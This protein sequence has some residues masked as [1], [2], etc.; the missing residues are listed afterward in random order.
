MLLL[1]GT[2]VMVGAVQKAPCAN[3]AWVEHRVGGYAH[4]YSDVTDLYEWEQLA[5]G[6]LPYLDACRPSVHL[7]DEYPVV[8]MYVMR[9]AAWIGGDQPEDFASF[10]WTNVLLLLSCALA[11]AWCLERL[12]AK[13][14]LFAAAPTLLVYGTMNWDLVP[15]A[16]ATAATYLF[17]RGRHSGTGIGLGLGAAAKVYPAL[18]LLPFAADDAG[19]RDVRGITRMVGWFGL[20]W[21]VVNVPFAIAARHQWATTFRFNAL[22]PPEADSLWRAVTFNHWLMGTR[23]INILS[24][25]IPLVATLV[26]WFVKERRQPGFPRWTLAFPLLATFLL[27]N[28]I[29]SPQYALWLL[30]WFALTATST[31]P[32][33]AYQLGELLVFFERFEYFAQV[34]SHGSGDYRPFAVAVILRA[35]L[36]LWCVVVWVRRPTPGV[37]PVSEAGEP[38]EA[39]PAAERSS[40]AAG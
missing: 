29:W 20:T 7:C 14:V 12:G 36:L 30:P 5:G 37:T 19:R 1:T 33:V 10:Y 26:I 17:L 3:R 28:K 13:T 6:R 32:F 34:N 35:V 25:A 27:A 21:L 9:A 11:V 40:L 22:R 18:L 23:A 2:V 15:V 4:C 24:F 8:S 39:E 31:I 38:A 16:L